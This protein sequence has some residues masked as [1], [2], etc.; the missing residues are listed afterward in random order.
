MTKYEAEIRKKMMKNK[1]D[2]SGT[3]YSKSSSFFKNLNER[4]STKA[5]KPNPNISKM[6]I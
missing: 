2:R 6:K 5:R 1:E 3:K 4:S